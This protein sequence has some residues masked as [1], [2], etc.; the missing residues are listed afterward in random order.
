MLVSQLP[1]KIPLPFANSGTKNAIPTASQIG[2]T[3]GAA[4]L[5][6]GFPPLTFTPLASGGV[7]PAGADF[8]GL[9][10]LITAIQQWQSAGGAFK[11]D[12]TFSTSI[13]GYPKGAVL[14]STSND[15][16]WLNLADGNTTD[17]DSVAS[18]NWV[19][20]DAYGVTA[21]TGL[22]N[23][24]V[25]LTPTQSGKPVITLAGTLSGNVQIIF[26]TWLQQWR[27]LNN[28]T[29]AFT[30]TCKTAAGTGIVVPQGGERLVYGDGT[31]LLQTGISLTAG[32]TGA[33]TLPAGT[34]AQRNG[35]PSV[36]DTRI[37]TDLGVLEAFIA[38]AWGSVGKIAQFASSITTNAVSSTVNVAL[39][40]QSF[41]PKMTGSKIL[42]IGFASVTAAVGTS[43]A[44]VGF[45]ITKAGSIFGAAAQG[46]LSTTTT[47]NIVVP[48]FIA[49]IDTTG[50]AGTPISYG[51]ACRVDSAGTSGVNTNGA[52]QH[53]I[54]ILEIEP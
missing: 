26:P 47:T 15:L 2:I 38:G 1:T 46:G 54:L 4:S 50:V 29:G 31:N 9:F 52:T 5:T 21:V 45:Y 39:D 12:A 43:N 33:A 44:Q 23:A 51:T 22:T 28:T 13:G 48:F 36:G 42:I 37:N 17:P 14:C 40:S 7:P 34:T 27:V 11:Y 30:V 53:G 35:T 16:Y 49:Q 10:N 20:L 25:T 6:D 3:A 32:T 8:N 24:N 41:T 19:V 18:A